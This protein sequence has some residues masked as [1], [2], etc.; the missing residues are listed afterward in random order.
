MELL[1]KWYT[2][3]NA[4][5]TQNISG[6]EEWKLFLQ[7]LFRLLGYNLESLPLTQ[8]SLN[9]NNDT[10]AKSKKQRVLDIG[11]DEDWTFMLK[12]S[13][14][15]IQGNKIATSLGLK[16]HS[17]HFHQHS[18]IKSN[19]DTNAILFPY[20][21]DILFS[22]HLVY[23]VCIILYSKKIIIIKFTL[24]FFFEDLKLNTMKTDLLPMIVQLLYQ[25]SIDLKL[26][27]YVH[28]YWKDHPLFCKRNY[29]CS[30]VS[31]LD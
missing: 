24:K 12:S 8:D 16:N 22:L 20:I 28:H 6:E 11:S 15:S 13:F 1:I 21:Y 7:M 30:K 19:I 14:N 17:Q 31:S 27:E 5:G 10:P 26:E 25:L 18:I 4:P 23:E 3:R 29:S 9:V 2:V